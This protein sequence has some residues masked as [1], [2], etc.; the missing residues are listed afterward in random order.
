MPYLSSAQ[1]VSLDFWATQEKIERIGV[2][3][4]TENNNRT[5]QTYFAFLL[6]LEEYGS[7]RY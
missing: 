5:Q 2:A 1:E 4:E 3:A 6:R 7:M